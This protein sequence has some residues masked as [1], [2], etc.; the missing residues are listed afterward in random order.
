MFKRENK[1]I[2]IGRGNSGNIDFSIPLSDSENYFF[3]VGDK[4]QFRIFLKK[5]IW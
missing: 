1:T 3:N 4:I 5:R 2:K